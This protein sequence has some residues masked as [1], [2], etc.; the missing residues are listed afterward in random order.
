[1]TKLKLDPLIIR[2]IS[3]TTFTLAFV[4]VAVRYFEV[5]LEVIWVLFVFSLI[6]VVGLIVLGV[7][8]AAVLRLLRRDK[9]GMLG[10]LEEGDYSSDRINR[11]DRNR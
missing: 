7:A 8:G 4:W 6:F 9:S 1:M 11:S 5:D 3:G 10:K 2:L